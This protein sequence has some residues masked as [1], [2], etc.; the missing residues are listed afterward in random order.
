MSPGGLGS[1]LGSGSSAVRRKVVGKIGSS[2]SISPT[3]A[4]DAGDDEDMEEGPVEPKGKA[5]KVLPGKKRAAKSKPAV[6]DESDDDDFRPDLASPT[7]SKK[8]RTTLAITDTPTATSARPSRTALQTSAYVAQHSPSPS[9]SGR[10][11]LESSSQRPVSLERQDAAP[12]GRLQEL[13]EANGVNTPGNRYDQHFLQ[14]HDFV[15]TNPVTR[16][17]ETVRRMAEPKPRLTA[18]QKVDLMNKAHLV[19]ITA[20]NEI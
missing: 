9:S 8:R 12:T 5:K 11:L 2:P 19:S 10:D 16:I 1:G 14:R 4:K 6:S 13:L 18:E 7:A 3:P 17:P 15:V 20:C